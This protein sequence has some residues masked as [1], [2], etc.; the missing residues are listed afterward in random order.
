MRK[1]NG[2]GVA[3]EH[4]GGRRPHRLDPVSLADL[5]RLLE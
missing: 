5:A 1:Q 2:P 3:R 4:P